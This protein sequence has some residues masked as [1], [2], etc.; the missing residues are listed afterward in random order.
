MTLMATDRSSR[1]TAMISTPASTQ[2]GSVSRA[3]RQAPRAAGAE[4]ACDL[5][6]DGDVSFCETGDVDGDGV[7]TAEGDCNDDD[8]QVGP[9]EPEKCGDGVDQDCAGGDLACSGLIDADSDG[10]P[11]GADC[12]D[13]DAAIGPDEVETCNGK[14]DDCDLLVDEGNPGGG[15]LCG[16]SDVGDCAFGNEQCQNSSG[17]AGQIVCVGAIEA[18]TSDVCDGHDE[19]CDGATDNFSLTS[20]CEV[21]NQFGTCKGSVSCVEV[22]MVCD[23]IPAAPEAC[24]G[25]DNDCSGAT[26]E[27]FAYEDKAIGA[28]CDGIGGCGTGTVECA[29][30]RTDLATCSTN[31]NGTHSGATTEVCDLEDNDCDGTT[32]EGGVCP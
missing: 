4:A 5:D 28:T 25:I 20:G 26:D 8:A 1:P 9:G 32:D 7:T 10:W 15:A 17:T 13:D 23:A 27:E 24:D 31:P 3:A 16:W 12:N 18:K 22:A 14:D 19:D 6:C 29:S 11:T 2:A 30:D 21:T